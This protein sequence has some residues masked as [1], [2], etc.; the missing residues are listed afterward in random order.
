MS[1][2]E[3]ALKRARSERGLALVPFA[4]T[5]GSAGDANRPASGAMISTAKESDLEA[6]VQSSAAIALMR[7]DALR[8][9]TELDVNG[10]IYPEM[11]ETAVAEAFRAIRTK[12][13]QKTLNRNC[14]I[15]VTSAASESGNTFVATNLAAAFAFDAG[16]TALIV[17]CNLRKPKLHGLLANGITHGLTDYLEN[18]GLDVSQIIYSAGIERLRVIPAGGRRE[19]PGE[20][21]TSEKMKRLL[22]S[23]RRRYPERFIILDAPPMSESADTQILAELCDYV[24][25]NVPYGK[26]TDAQVERCIKA[27]DSKKLVGVVFNGEPRMPPITLALLVQESSGLLRFWATECRHWVVGQLKRKRHV[28]GEQ[29]KS[30]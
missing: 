27:I 17:D 8:S 15:M 20:Y 30:R 7:E 21:F 5:N 3:K 12:I 14:V 9:R 13:L 19:I 23:A 24:L 11:P 28:G 22:E 10:V 1:K 29:D 18:P 6:R 2:V 25:L 4:R 16:M 26:V